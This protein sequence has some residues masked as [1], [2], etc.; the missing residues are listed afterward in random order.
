MDFGYLGYLDY[1]NYLVCSF[2]YLVY[3]FFTYIFFSYFF[4]Y[5]LSYFFIKVDLF[6]PTDGKFFLTYV[7]KEDLLAV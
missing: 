1:F 7:S 4:S 2:A 6:K 5:F 3:V